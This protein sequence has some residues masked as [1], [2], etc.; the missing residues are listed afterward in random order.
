MQRGTPHLRTNGLP[1]GRNPN[2]ECSGGLCIR[3]AGFFTQCQV[4]DGG[5]ATMTRAMMEPDSNGG[6][7][8]GPGSAGSLISIREWAQSVGI[9]VN[10]PDSSISG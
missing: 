4:S 10:D 6:T 7:L 8:G 3:K 1:Q 5:C 2:L 9:H